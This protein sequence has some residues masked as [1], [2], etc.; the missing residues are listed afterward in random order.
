MVVFAMDVCPGCFAVLLSACALQAFY[1][2]TAVLL[3]LLLMTPMLLL[4]SFHRSFAGTPSVSG[5]P[6]MDT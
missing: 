1:F 2:L 5:A 4:Y 3:M 6:Q